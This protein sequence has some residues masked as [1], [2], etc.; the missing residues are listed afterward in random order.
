MKKYLA[1]IA[2][3]AATAAGIVIGG[4]GPASAEV[5][6]ADHTDTWS[7]CIYDV[8][9][10]NPTSRVIAWAPASGGESSGQRVDVRIEFQ[11]GGV[12]E[13]SAGGGMYDQIQP[14]PVKRACIVNKVL[15]GD[16]AC[17]G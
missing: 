17:A 7:I 12:V 5:C 14:G 10:T 9:G 8:P 15:G 16:I 2:V 1:S 4:A 3:A 11:A 6:G 13:E